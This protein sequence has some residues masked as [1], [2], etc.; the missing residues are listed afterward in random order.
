MRAEAN[1]CGIFSHS[2]HPFIL[3]GRGAK[4]KSLALKKLTLQMEKTED[5][6]FC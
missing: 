4:K 6:L 3:G 1:E 2:L 5:K